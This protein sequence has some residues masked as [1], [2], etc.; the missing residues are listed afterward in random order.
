MWQ[1][2]AEGN[3]IGNQKAIGGKISRY[4][5]QRK[6]NGIRFLKIR[7]LG[8]V[9]WEEVISSVR[10]WLRKDI[11]LPPLFITTCSVPMMQ[12]LIIRSSEMYT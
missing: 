6:G 12:W 9:T 5:R 1:L 2:D 7:F 3:V 4:S 8:N 11:S 10:C